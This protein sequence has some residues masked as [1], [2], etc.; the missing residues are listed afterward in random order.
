MKKALNCAAV[1]L[2]ASEGKVMLGSFDGAKVALQ[3]L[4][5]FPN[6]PLQEKNSIY[7]DVARLFEEVK[8]GLGM[9][10]RLA[11][12]DSIGLDA[13]GNDFCLLS[14]NGS[15]LENPH[16]YRDPRTDGVMQKAFDVMSRTDIY[17]RTGVQ[18]M[19][20]N[21]LFQLYSMVQAGSP[22]LKSAATYL[23]TADLFNYW[24][25]GV[26]C[27]EFTNATTTQFFDPYKED[28]CLP[29]LEAFAIPVNIMPPIV[30]P[31]MELATLES[32]LQDEL[33]LPVV[34]VIAVGTHDTASAVSVVPVR[35][36]DYAF[37]SSGTWS[38]LGAEVKEPLISRTGLEHN[39]SCYGGVGGAW[40]VWKNI[41]ALW[42]LQECMRTWKESGWPGG[43]DELTG[44]A[45]QA[46]PF[47]SFID[48]DD[49][50]FLTPGDLPA[51]IAEYCRRSGQAPPDG[52]GATVRCILESL[53]LKYRYTF[54]KLQVVLS[55]KLNRIHIVGGGSRNALLNR[56]T[57]G[58]TGV[59]V[60]AGPA[61]AT[62]LGNF[63]AQL[64]AKGEVGSLSEA[65]EIVRRSFGTVTYLP[66]E[67]AGWDEAYR[68]F[69]AVA[70]PSR[71]SRKDSNNIG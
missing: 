13:W 32:W 4:Y 66:G 20:H 71:A 12:L 5:R 69:S 6:G 55:R 16:S 64:M 58:A 28:W 63:M 61:E 29:I 15:L 65:R 11:S 17:Q 50:L 40:L 49:R 23:M 57:A 59:T 37:L 35:D 38:L 56:F 18:F 46:Q 2:G 52:R 53:A 67:R 30:R 42:L 1:D 8:R 48:V 68:R 51:R 41:Q 54:E 36:D 22:L 70:G 31:A 7:W 62:A 3:E 44:L 27:C 10:G 14:R 39:F 43:L 19:Q 34:P 47:G 45:Q 26:K 21:T 24:L 33:S 60:V 25:C 9:A